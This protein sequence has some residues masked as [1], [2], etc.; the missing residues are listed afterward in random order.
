MR[1]HK[2]T[3]TKRKGKRKKGR[4]SPDQSGAGCQPGKKRRKKRNDAGEERGGMKVAVQV[5]GP[6]VSFTTKEKGKRRGLEER[7]PVDPRGMSPKGGKRGGRGVAFDEEGNGEPGPLGRVA[8]EEKGA[9]RRGRAYGLRRTALKGEEGVSLL[10]KKER[11]RLPKGKPPGAPGGPEKK[12]CRTQEERK[13]RGKWPRGISI[14]TWRGRRRKRGGSTLSQK[15]GP[16]MTVPVPDSGERREGNARPKEGRRN[17]FDWTVAFASLRGG[18]G[19]NPPFSG[20]RVCDVARGFRDRHRIG[21]EE[22]NGL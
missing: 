5:A 3:T 19:P 8:S 16:A 13:K 18:G 10:E 12:N 11:G 17:G 7:A 1:A 20:G 4:L 2:E 22:K 15:G 6:P 21:R 9:K 14:T